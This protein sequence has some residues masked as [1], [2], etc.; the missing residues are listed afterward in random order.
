MRDSLFSPSW[1][2]VNTLKPRIRSHVEIHRHSYRKEPW[3]VLQDHVSGR[4]QRFTPDT[5]FLIGL[6]DGERTVE[7]I[8]QA[9][10]ARLGEDAP[11]QEEMIRLLSQL[12]AVD[13]LQSDVPPDTLELL[14]RYEKRPAV[15]WKQ[16]L[17]N[18]LAMRF[19]LF[20]PESFLKRFSPFVRPVFSWLGAFVWLTVVIAGLVLTGLHWAEL[21]E[22]VTDRI[23]A[24][25]NLVLLWFIFPC[26]KAVHEFGHAFA[27]KVLGGEVHEMGIMFLVLT[28]IPYV[29]AS[30]ATSFRNKWERALV[31]AA[32][33]GV[34]LFLAS[35]ALI[36]W[37]NVEP[38][39]IRAVLYNIILVGGLSSLVFNGNP[40]LRY[41]GYYILADLI[42]I[43]NLAPRG[44][45]YLIYLTQ[46]YLFGVRE[47]EPPV[48]TS[49]ERV[50]FVIYTVLSFFY[51]I[52]IYVRIIQF[53]A[54]KFW[55]IGFLLALWMMS[56][57]L[58]LPIFKST[59]FL[60]FS[61]RL[62]RKRVRAIAVSAAVVVA[63]IAIITL[64]PVPLGTVAE[65]VMWFPDESFA[66]AG[67][68][69]FVDKL[70][71][72]SGIQVK[73]GDLLV[74]CSDPLLPVRIRVLE[75]QIRELQVEYDMNERTNLV[76][77]QV[78]QDE[79]ENV[80]GELTDARR[81]ADEL[82]IYSHAEGVFFVP[83]AQDLPG[84]FVRRGEIVGYVLNKNLITARVV[85][86]QSD[87]DLVRSRTY[88]VRVR[89]PE[90]INETISSC[91]VREVPG[92][93]DQLP[94][95]VLSQS[96]GGE[97]AV[98]P[99]DQKGTKAFQRIFLFDI[100]L[101][102]QVYGFNVGGRVH[103]RFDHGFEPLA[104]RWY[105]NIRQLLLRR[106]NV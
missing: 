54:G 27:I 39:S 28:P 1:Y 66:R 51:R 31:G 4:F 46:H 20:D 50:W 65:G 48:S 10:R 22:N 76:K 15:K 96:G 102:S 86:P 17:K 80:K 6:M 21:T 5:H 93:T 75:A 105:R 18:P 79:I 19:S 36:L 49:G 67:A 12:H 3:Y 87:V 33:I 34:E 85:V 41:D 60:F 94:S 99:R 30:S 45:Q 97:V 57:M 68:D 55:T 64:V 26:L 83:T 70:A 95:K 13:A 23:L 63:V 14:K 42:E 29:D 2:R 52:F 37:V 32:G 24:P 90:R 98:D 103:V 71:T 100:Q 73:Q 104:W 74:E 78:T 72:A 43:P 9:A 44:T 61:P 58:V 88:G 35:L 91:L 56:T 82:K 89:L 106:F 84:K 16:N 101:P 69:G 92:G 47:A 7:E 77:A 62:G 40:L 8:W 53:I 11:T 59:K 25:T 38:G 81:R